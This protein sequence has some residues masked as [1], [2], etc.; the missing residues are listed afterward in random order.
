MED[1]YFR[2]SRFSCPSPQQAAGYSNKIKSLITDENEL[3]EDYRQK[4]AIEEFIRLAERP[5]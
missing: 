1:A 4:L 5:S 2:L 3:I